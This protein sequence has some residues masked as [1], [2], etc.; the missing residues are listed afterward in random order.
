MSWEIAEMLA[1]YLEVPLCQVKE[2]DRKVI[3]Y[4]HN[5]HNTFNAFKRGCQQTRWEIYASI[6]YAGIR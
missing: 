2:W 4:L 1:S 5:D 3:H 6:K